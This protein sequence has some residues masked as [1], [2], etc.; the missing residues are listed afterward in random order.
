LWLSRTAPNTIWIGDTAVGKTLRDVI[1]WDYDYVSFDCYKD[2]H[3]NNPSSSGFPKDSIVPTTEK[4]ANENWNHQKIFM[5]PYVG[6]KLTTTQ[7]ESGY[8]WVTNHLSWVETNLEEYFNY[9]AD[10]Q[11]SEIVGLLPFYWYDTIHK[12]WCGAY[13]FSG[14]IDI[15]QSISTK[16]SERG[17]SW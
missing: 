4:L 2:C 15:L 9:A 17:L 11:N 12:D 16:I 13:R 10:E 8:P 5:I 14:Q 7:C 6:A 3:F 1:P